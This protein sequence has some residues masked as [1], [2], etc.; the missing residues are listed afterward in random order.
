MLKEVKE[1]YCKLSEPCINM[2]IIES[3]LRENYGIEAVRLVAPSNKSLRNH[4]IYVE[5]SRV[6]LTTPAHVKHI[7]L[8]SVNMSWTQVELLMRHFHLVNNQFPQPQNN[9]QVME[10]LSSASATERLYLPFYISSEVTSHDQGNSNSEYKVTNTNMM[11]KQEGSTVDFITTPPR[12][13]GPLPSPPGLE[14]VNCLVLV[15]N[16]PLELQRHLWPEL[17]YLQV[18]VTNLTHILA[19]KETA[20][21]L[22]YLKL[23][24][25]ADNIPDL[26][27]TLDWE[28]LPWRTGFL[29]YGHGDINLHMRGKIT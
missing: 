13:K 19:L 28:S 3:L 15:E 7:Q 2:R 29:I 8:Q 10:E 9:Q 5:P 6:L 21:K 11:G 22:N 16:I 12:Q 18:Q 1:L 26:V 14:T 4:S 27:W 23:V 17:R 24:I 20:P 25:P